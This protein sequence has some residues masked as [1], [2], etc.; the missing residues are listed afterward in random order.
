MKTLEL[1]HCLTSNP[2]TSVVYGGIFPRNVLLKY[3]RRRKPRAFI[4]NIHLAHKKGQHW[5]LVYFKS[6]GTAV[7]FDSYELPPTIYPEFVQ[8]LNDNSTTFILL[9]NQVFLM[10]V[11]SIL[12]SVVY[13]MSPYTLSSVP[14]HS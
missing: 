1:H 5:I 13:L 7:Y 12:S 14:T 2:T 9:I 6:N 8:F 11:V 4:A 3:V 10:N